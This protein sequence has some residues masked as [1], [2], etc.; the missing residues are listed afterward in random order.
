MTTA[1]NAEV[2]REVN[3]LAFAQ[4]FRGNGN[5][6]PAINTNTDNNKHKQPEVSSIAFSEPSS[7]RRKDRI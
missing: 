1:R 2:L 4:E 6:N 7:A 3:F 5:H